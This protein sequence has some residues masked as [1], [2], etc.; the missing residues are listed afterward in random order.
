LFVNTFVCAFKYLDWLDTS[1]E[2]PPRRRPGVQRKLFFTWELRPTG[3]GK[4]TFAKKSA[5][6][7]F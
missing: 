3:Q 2:A 1:Q 6:L 5:S 4:G 7:E